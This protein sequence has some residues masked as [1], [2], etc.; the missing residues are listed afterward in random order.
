MIRN[1][2]TFIPGIG[3]KTEATY[4]EKGIVTWEDF[5]KRITLN[6]IG[7]T[8]KKVL[9]DYIQ[10]AKQALNRIHLTEKYL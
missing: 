6:S 8:N 10:K 4:W 1:T 7:K 2:F 3:S 9:I 5:E